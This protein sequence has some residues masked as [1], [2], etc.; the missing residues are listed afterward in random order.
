MGLGKICKAFLVFFSKSAEVLRIEPVTMSSRDDWRRW[1]AQGFLHRRNV[2]GLTRRSLVARH[3]RILSLD[4]L[5]CLNSA[6]RHRMEYGT[7]VEEC[8]G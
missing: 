8:Q 1:G 5:K 4:W 7:L 6:L 3:V 2:P